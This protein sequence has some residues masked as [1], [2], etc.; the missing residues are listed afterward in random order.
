MRHV[1]SG[2]WWYLDRLGLAFPENELPD[3]TWEQLGKVRQLLV[4]RM[5]SFAGSN[6]VVGREGELW[7]PRKVLRRAVWHERDHIGHIQKLLSN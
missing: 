4:D 6:Q 2:E 3:D 5:M 1:A 7:S